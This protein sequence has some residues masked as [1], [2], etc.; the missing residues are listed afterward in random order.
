MTKQ[1]GSGSEKSA[2][3]GLALGSGLGV[4][5]RRGIWC[6]VR[7]RRTR[8]RARHL[9]RCGYRSG[10]WRAQGIKVTR[11]DLSADEASCTVIATTVAHAF[12]R[13]LPTRLLRRHCPHR[14]GG[15]RQVY[16]PTDMQNGGMRLLG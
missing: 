3:R 7:Q 2:G 1:D 6:G 15:M 14:R 5:F 8:C 13:R 4:A 10:V 12:N 9:L 11:L 16:N